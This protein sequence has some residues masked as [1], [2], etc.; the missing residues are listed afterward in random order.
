[1]NFEKRQVV[2][3]TVLAVMIS[4]FIFFQYLPVSRAIARSK[5]EQQIAQQQAQLDAA[6]SIQLPVMQE[7]IEQLSQ[8]VGDFDAKIPTDRDFGGF[9]QNI[10]D[11]MNRNNLKDQ[12]V[13]PSAEM[14]LDKIS[15]IPVTIE[16]SGKLN[17]IFGFLRDFE[18]S[19][20][21]CNLEQ[22][23]IENENYSGN[24]RL[25]AKGNIFYR[26]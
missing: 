7:K 10:T 1:M 14:N 22:I 13:K 24:L 17:D 4:A 9:M 6:N 3:F 23:R 25:F 11:V 15:I 12:L 5:E 2:I 19:P 18:A 21:I 20:R 16:C 26:Q 8:K